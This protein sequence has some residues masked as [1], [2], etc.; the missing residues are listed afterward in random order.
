MHWYRCYALSIASEDISN[1]L[2]RGIAVHLGNR[3]GKEN[4]FGAYPNAILGI[5]ATG[6]AIGPHD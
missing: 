4:I 2:Y 1:A 5:A 3:G 6:Y